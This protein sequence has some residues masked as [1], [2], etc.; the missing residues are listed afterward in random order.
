MYTISE[1]ISSNPTA[2][3]GI[4]T[5]VGTVVI[6]V[7]D[8]YWLHKNTN[9]VIDQ[10]AV[11]RQELKDELEVVRTELRELRNEVDEWREKYYSQVETTNELL[12]EVYTLK[13][14]LSQYET[15]TGTFE[16]P[17]PHE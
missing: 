12:Y 5:V 10:H 6:K 7:L 14:R 2:A 1:I 16:T 4:I 11:L 3:A 15:V 8:G 9:S 17:E 13:E